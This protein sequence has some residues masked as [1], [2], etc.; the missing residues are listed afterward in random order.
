MVTSILVAFPWQERNMDISK[1][2]WNIKCH[3]WTYKGGWP[4]MKLFYNIQT[5][6][7][8]LL[9]LAFPISGGVA[10]ADFLFPF[11]SISSIFLCHSHCCQISLYAVSPSSFLLSLF[12][13][14]IFLITFISS[15]YVSKPPQ[16]GQ[17]ISTTYSWIIVFSDILQVTL[18]YLLR[19]CTDISNQCQI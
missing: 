16:S 3:I 9:L 10:S 1:P 2:Q 17:N 18:H 5:Q 4:G 6:Q 11:S 13:T 19:N 12:P 15:L 8:L 14:C 7:L